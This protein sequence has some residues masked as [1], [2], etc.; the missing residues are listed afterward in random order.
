MSGII[1]IRAWGCYHRVVLIIKMVSTMVNILIKAWSFIRCIIVFAISVVIISYSTDIPF[2]D[3]ML[4]FGRSNYFWFDGRHLSLISS[5]P[6]FI[7]L[8][9]MMATVPFTKDNQIPKSFYYWGNVLG[10]ISLVIFMLFSILSLMTYFYIGYFTPYQLCKEPSTYSH[11]FAKDPAICKTIV[12]R[13][14]N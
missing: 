9:I 5:I 3:F 1:S 2:H 6:A 11:Y 14:L 4:F 10:L 13:E 7:Y 12:N 8:S